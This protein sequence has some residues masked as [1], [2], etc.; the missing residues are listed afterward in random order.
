[1]TIMH[2][3]PTPNPNPQGWGHLTYM[4]NTVMYVYKEPFGVIMD[5]FKDGLLS[6]ASEGLTWM[7][8]CQSLCPCTSQDFFVLEKFHPGGPSLLCLKPFSRW[9]SLHHCDSVWVH[10]CNFRLDSA[11]DAWLLLSRSIA[12]DF[13]GREMSPWYTEKFLSTKWRVS[14]SYYRLVLCFEDHI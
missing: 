8:H 9:E 10:L 7:W 1:M 3:H 2:K 12:S 4:L 14:D 11:N 6:M 13:V 5:I